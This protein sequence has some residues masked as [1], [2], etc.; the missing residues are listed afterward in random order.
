[1]ILFFIGLVKDTQARNLSLRSPLLFSTLD[2]AKK[3]LLEGTATLPGL[4]TP[5]EEPQVQSI[6]EEVESPRTNR[7]SSGRS[8]LGSQ[9]S[10][11]TLTSS[12]TTISDGSQYEDGASMLCNG[13]KT[14]DGF[15]PP[16]LTFGSED[17]DDIETP[18]RVQL[19]NHVVATL[20]LLIS[21]QLTSVES[22]GQFAKTALDREK[23]FGKLLS[24]KGMSEEEKLERIVRG[25]ANGWNRPRFNPKH[26]KELCDRALGE[27]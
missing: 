11:P 15:S 10:S 22:Y 4:S 19:Y 7:P 12:G 24:S 3:S 9:E 16:S 23:R 6:M 17:F 21:R 27:L 26:Y 2:E 5:S 14:I 13:G 18:N 20:H 1:M 25:R 8:S